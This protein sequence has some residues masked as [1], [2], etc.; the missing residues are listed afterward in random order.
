MFRRKTAIF[1]GDLST[2]E[3]PLPIPN[4]VVKPSYA[5]DTTQHR[6]GKVGHCRS[7]VQFFDLVE[8]LCAPQSGRCIVPI[9]YNHF[10]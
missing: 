3:T 5:D 8:I 6:V 1:C 7:E 4:R 9:W 2:G 10:N